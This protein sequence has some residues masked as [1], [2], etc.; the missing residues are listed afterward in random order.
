MPVKEIG[1]ALPQGIPRDLDTRVKHLSKLLANLPT[2]LPLN[3]PADDSTYH[4]Y[5]DPD[6][7]ENEGDMLPSTEGLRLLS[8]P[9]NSGGRS[10]FSRNGASPVER[11]VATG[12]PLCVMLRNLGNIF[13]P[14][15]RVTSLPYTP[16]YKHVV[17]AGLRRSVAKFTTPGQSFV[18]ARKNAIFTGAAGTSRRKHYI[19]RI[20]SRA[21]GVARWIQTLHGCPV[22]Y[23][24]PQ[25]VAR[26][27]VWEAT[28][29][30]ADALTVLKCWAWLH[31]GP[32]SAITLK[33]IS[34]TDSDQSGD[35]NSEFNTTSRQW[36]RK[37]DDGHLGAQD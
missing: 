28:G 34:A 36:R 27:G 13:D 21:D 22:Q 3:P 2:T 17:P 18:K 6:D 9:T 4:F 7:V 8:R 25:R 37:S 30:E 23:T 26:G 14:P 1:P 20:I 32:E 24:E 11:G 10:W 19:T 29:A 16:L 31:L 5:L 35:L 12:P 33:D 15:L